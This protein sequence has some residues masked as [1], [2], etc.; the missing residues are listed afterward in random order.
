MD[1]HSDD[2]DELHKHY[3]NLLS[4]ATSTQ[5][6]DITDT[7]RLQSFG[8]SISIASTSSLVPVPSQSL[9]NNRVYKYDDED[10]DDDIFTNNRSCWCYSWWCCTLSRADMMRLYVIMAM[11]MMTAIITIMLRYPSS[12]FNIGA[13][14]T[15]L[16]RAT[17][18]APHRHN[19]SSWNS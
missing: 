15:S 10:D 17:H 1:D 16:H 14:P 9:S 7:N 11:I 3:D 19:T 5:R 13:T 4:A 2:A 6:N 8:H 12:F 18:V